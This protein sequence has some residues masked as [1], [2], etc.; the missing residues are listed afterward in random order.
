VLVVDDDEAVRD[1]LVRMIRDAG[2]RAVE[3]ENG[4]VALERLEEARPDLIL[5]DLVM[6]EMD[7]F[8]LATRL[9]SDPAWRSVPVVVVTGKDLTEED[10][11]RLNG[12]VAQVVQK[13]DVAAGDLVEQLRTLMGARRDPA[14]PR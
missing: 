4:V 10:R 12:H 3:A 11:R 13:Q 14:A 1:R 6:P 2:W 5:L 8:T 9:R 7:G